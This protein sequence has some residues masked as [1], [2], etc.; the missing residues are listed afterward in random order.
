MFFTSHYLWYLLIKKEWNCEIPLHTLI[1][2]WTLKFNNCN[3]YNQLE[4]STGGHKQ[5]FTYVRFIGIGIQTIPTNLVLLGFWNIALLTY[6]E[7]SNPAI[8]KC[9]KTTWIRRHGAQ[10]LEIQGI[11]FLLPL[12]SHLAFC[13]DHTIS[14]R[15]LNH[16]STLDARILVAKFRISP[17]RNGEFHWILKSNIAIGNYFH[18]FWNRTPSLV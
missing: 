7:Q 3:I 16:L 13:G 15:I 6:R 11:A 12:K 8:S 17:R 18:P 14:L 9:Q 5:Y 1:K 2:H 4:S 10:E